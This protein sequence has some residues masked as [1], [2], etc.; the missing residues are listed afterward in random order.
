MNKGTAQP[1]QEISGDGQISISERLTY[2]FRNTVRNLKPTPLTIHAEPYNPGFVSNDMAVAPPSSALAL[3][4]LEQQIQSVLPV[5]NIRILDV[6]C[7]SSFISDVLPNHGYKGVYTGIDIGDHFRDRFAL[8]ESF[9]RTFINVTSY[10]DKHW[11]FIAQ[12]Q[13]YFGYSPFTS[14][15]WLRPLCFFTALISGLLFTL[16]MLVMFSRRRQ[17][18]LK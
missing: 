14:Y 5:G 8:P 15:H 1:V 4:F 13:Q 2:L 10:A 17:G 16:T 11:R 7:G 3:S 18:G 9:E 12:P 6:G